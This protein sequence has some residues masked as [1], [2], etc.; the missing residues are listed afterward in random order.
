[1]HRGGRGAA[2]EPRVQEGKAV[3]AGVRATL[4]RIM[5]GFWRWCHLLN[6]GVW[7]SGEWVNTNDLVLKPWSKML[8]H[9]LI[10]HCL[11]STLGGVRVLPAQSQPFLWIPSPPPLPLHLG[12]CYLLFSCFL[13][14]FYFSCYWFLP[15]IL[16]C[17]HAKLLQSCPAPC[18]TTDHGPPG[19]SVHRILQARILEWV[20]MP[21][22][23][24]SS[25]PRDQIRIS[26]SCINHIC[27]WF[28]RATWGDPSSSYLNF[29]PP[30]ITCSCPCI[31]FPP[32]HP[33]FSAKKD[34]H[35]LSP[36]LFFSWL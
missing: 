35:S 22:S 9:F 4:R 16:L 36:H 8:L 2:K 29:S 25:Q 32:S 30:E 11:P 10:T 27:W 7:S 15:F 20:A 28:T 17:M 23:R 31:P 5:K 34:L 26:V 19:S 24:G 21:F 14:Y 6:Q 12:T 18:D 33:K 1:M 13:I 3:M